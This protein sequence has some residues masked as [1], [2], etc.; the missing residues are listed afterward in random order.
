MEY[1]RDCYQ[2]KESEFLAFDAMRVAAQCV[3]RIIRGKSDY[4]LMVFADKV[5]N[6]SKCLLHELISLTSSAS[7]RYSRADKKDKLPAWIRAQIPDQHSNLSTDVAIHAT[8]EFLKQMAQPW[9]KEEQL[10]H[11]LWYAAMYNRVAN[12]NRSL[13]HVLKQ[14]ASKPQGNGEAAPAPAPPA[15]AAR[16]TAMDTT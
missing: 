2:I 6:S 9:S 11:S 14:P 1:L 5:T 12:W 15:A 10:G 16:P 13:E 8:R 3:G 7:Q 4:G